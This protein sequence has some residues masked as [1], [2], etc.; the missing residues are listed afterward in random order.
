MSERLAVI[1][2]YLVSAEHDT[3]WYSSMPIDYESGTLTMPCFSGVVKQGSVG[4]ALS[5]T[6]NFVL[7]VIEGAPRWMWNDVLQCCMLAS[8]AQDT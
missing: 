2:G 6:G 5:A 4:V 3:A 8:E 7:V 1:S